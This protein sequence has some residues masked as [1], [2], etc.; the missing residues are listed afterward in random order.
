MNPPGPPAAAPAPTGPAPPAPAPDDPIRRALFAEAGQMFR[1]FVQLRY[2]SLL[3]FGGASAALIALYFQY[4]VLDHSQSWAIRVLATVI[5]FLCA[6]FEYRIAQLVAH[7]QNEMNA[8]SAG[9]GQDPFTPPGRRLLGF[10]NPLDAAPAPVAD[11]IPASPRVWGFEIT[12]L[13]A[14][15][16]YVAAGCTWAFFAYLPDGPSLGGLIWRTVERLMK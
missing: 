7:F 5:S 15:T 16:I 4:H 6:V 10:E 2:Y 1:H 8:I 14:R 13:A 3:G 12:S 11:F 9:W